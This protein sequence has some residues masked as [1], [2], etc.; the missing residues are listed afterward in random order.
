MNL[1]GTI[2]FALFGSIGVASIFNSYY[3]IQRQFPKYDFSG[4]LNLAIILLCIVVIFTILLY[5]FTVIGLDRGNYKGAKFFT[6]IGILVGW[7]GW[8]IPSIVFI[9]SF[10][11]F[12]EAIGRIKKI[13]SP[14]MS[15]RDK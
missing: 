9:K 6:L 2:F 11:S 13:E 5:R 7:I 8:I 3:S 15:L 14:K 4:T 10:L 12:D 1:V